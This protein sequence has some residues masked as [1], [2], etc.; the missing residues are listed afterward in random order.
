MNRAAGQFALLMILFVAQVDAGGPLLV[1]GPSIGTAGQ[2]LRWNGVVEYR[3]D[4]G[5]LGLLTNAQAMQRVQA[6]FQAWQDVPTASITFSRLGGITGVPDGDV[7]TVEEFIAVDT[8]CGDGMQTP[9]IYDAN[10][11]LLAGLGLP[12]GVIGFTGICKVIPATGSIVSAESVLNGKF[13]DGNPANFELTNEQFDEAFT[14]EFGH[15]A[16]L[17]HSQINIEIFQQPFDGCSA[18]SLAGLPL[19]FPFVY[20]QSRVSAGLPRLAPDDIAWISRLY[21]ETVNDPGNGKVPFNTAY[22]TISGHVLFSDGLSAAQGVNVIARQVDNPAT[23]ENESKRVAVS[24]VSGYRFTGN[25]GQ[26]EAGNP[27]DSLGSRDP[28]LISTFDIP[29][30][31]G[32]YTVEVEAIEPEFVQGSSVG[33]F[34]FEQFPLPGPPEFWNLAESAV[35]DPAAKDVVSVSAGATT[36][37]D[38]IL[39]G[40]PPR[41]DPYEDSGANFPLELW[42]WWPPEQEQPEVFA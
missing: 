28:L 12:A 17:D 39:N 23:P 22:G 1:G 27:P 10:G 15:M 21:P 7:S 24:V 33:P 35:D 13:L 34:D 9:I 31:P 14:H 26:A 42:P 16:G 29:V 41:F 11:S 3:T 2:P 40:T 25:V 5:A 20:C 36:N 38:I 8:S 18:D 37:V 19:M 4:G 32:D 30:P 6:M